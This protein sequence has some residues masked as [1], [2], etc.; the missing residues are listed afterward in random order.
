MPCNRHL[1]HPATIHYMLY[2]VAPLRGFARCTSLLAIVHV[3]YKQGFDLKENFPE[4]C[5]TLSAIYVHHVAF[6]DRVDEG[7]ANMKYSTRGSLRKSNNVVQVWRGGTVEF[8]STHF[9][10]ALPELRLG[11]ERESA[12]VCV[13]MRVCVR[14]QHQQIF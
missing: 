13:C 9:V 5:T 12:C 7:L 11:H 6:V 4:L 2:H 1:D 8:V 14:C 10:T 3:A